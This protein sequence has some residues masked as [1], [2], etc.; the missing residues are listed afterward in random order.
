MRPIRKRF[1]LMKMSLKELRKEFYG[2][3]QAKQSVFKKEEKLS[4]HVLCFSYE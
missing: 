2:P 3:Q 1:S 4:V